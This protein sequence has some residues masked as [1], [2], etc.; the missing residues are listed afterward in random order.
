MFKVV[1]GLGPEVTRS[2]FDLDHNT[3]SER[4]FL[5]PHVN[6]LNN[7]GNSIRYFGPVVWDDMLPRKLKLIQTLEKFKDEIKKWAPINCPCTLCK[8]YIGGVGYINITN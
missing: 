8:E 6:S 2:L 7:G 3:R 1:K 4:S 5:G